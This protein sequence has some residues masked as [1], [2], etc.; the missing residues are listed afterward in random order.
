[1]CFSNFE[2]YCLQNDYA[3]IGIEQK[4]IAL[5]LLLHEW[6]IL[7]INGKHFVLKKEIIIDYFKTNNVKFLKTNF[8]LT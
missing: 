5:V 2:T 1:M 8:H 4:K 6:I 3:L 7:K